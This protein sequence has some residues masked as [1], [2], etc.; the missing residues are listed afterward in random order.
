VALVAEHEEAA[1]RVV[2][3][4]LGTR[5]VLYDRNIGRSVPDLRVE[6]TDR[7][8][9]YVEVV[10][11]ES[12]DWRSLHAALDRGNRVVEVPGLAY[13]WWIWPR[14][15][16]HVKTLTAGLPG[17]LRQL[18][19]AGETFGH[20]VGVELDERIARSPFRDTIT[21]L[22]IHRLVAGKAA[23]GDAV[24]RF[25]L[26]GTEGPVDIDLDRVSSWCAEFL[27]APE[28]ADVRTKLMDTGADERHAFIVVTISTEWP[29][30]H[31]LSEQIYPQ[32]P[33]TSPDLPDEVTHV[34]L[35]S[36]L[37]QRCIAWLPEHG[38]WI[39]YHDLV[40][41]DVG[42]RHRRRI[43]AQRGLPQAE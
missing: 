43:A 36:E 8:H 35:F 2:E 38:G 17:L 33:S 15:D 16:A 21:Q 1:R 13:H 4:V 12:Q 25:V 3:Q 6:Y 34:W 39:D 19:R 18:D 23:S 30:W 24:A 26:P 31:A 28:R 40:W 27:R 22:G 32:L 5:V 10:A 14:P 42:R 37:R 29:V 41:P 20:T 7:P 11:D 9:G